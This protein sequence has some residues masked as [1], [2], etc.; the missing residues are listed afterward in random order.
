MARKI[1]LNGVKATLERLFGHDDDRSLLAK[2]AGKQPLQQHRVDPAKSSNVFTRSAACDNLIKNLLALD[3]VFD[4]QDFVCEVAKGEVSAA[5]LHQ[6]IVRAK[7]RLEKKISAY[8]YWADRL[9]KL[10][11]ILHEHPSLEDLALEDRL[12]TPDRGD[13]G[14][15]STPYAVR[16]V[17]LLEKVEE[18]GRKSILSP[19]QLNDKA[20]ALFRMGLADQA[21]EIAREVVDA[22]PE[23]AESWML[24]A[25]HA[26][27]Q[28]RASDRDV[29]YY[30]FQQEEADPMSSHERWAEDMRDMAE[31]R[32]SEALTNHRTIVFSA[33]RYWPRDNENPHRRY[34]YRANYE[35]I[36][37]WCLDWLFGLTS[38]DTRCLSTGV[39]WL[40]ANEVRDGSAS[41]WWKENLHKHQERWTA[42]EGSLQHLSSL[43]IE[44][45]RHLCLEWQEQALAHT[46]F[47]FFQ[48]DLLE[49]IKP[50]V[51]LKL[52]HVH[53]VLSL[54]GYSEMRDHFLDSLRHLRKEDL[55]VILH[56]PALLHTFIL[57]CGSLG[58]ADML[59][60]FNRIV[61]KIGEE[62]REQFL[63]FKLNLMRRAY[64]QAFGRAEFSFCVEVARDAHHVLEKAPDYEPKELGMDESQGNTLSAKHWKYLELR[65]AVEI[66]A[67]S[68]SA[69]TSLLSVNEPAAYFSQ[70]AAYLIQEV[71]DFEFGEEC[72]VAP[73][74]D[75]IITSGQWLR[76][77]NELVESGALSDS[78]TL[79]DADKL[80]HRLAALQVIPGEETDF[81]SLWHGGG[82]GRTG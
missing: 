26:I 39:D 81:S 73:Y 38:P 43:E 58:S 56:Q 40:R 75:S 3:A 32:R 47:S 37:N 57:H 21:I 67:E 46:S 15:G 5:K 71:V 44:V 19:K 36:R 9:D 52:L 28:K 61:D 77:V 24:L 80:L 25:I 59:E 4:S 50:F 55:S 60:R 27:E 54:P 23:H 53:H 13:V 69:R 64:H 29:A 20:W 45:A 30:E 78:Q 74:G 48:R 70:E 18:Q 62:H 79:L 16:A 22:D 10:E 82:Q 17:R 65:A 33:L 8:G 68:E 72:Y 14:G 12:I 34:R 31:A 1:E 35:Q 42:N 66:W 41:V 49:S 51:P 11:A 7:A 6:E 63:L 76:A 2:F